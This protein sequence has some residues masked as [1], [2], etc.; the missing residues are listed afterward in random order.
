MRWRRLGLVPGADGTA[1]WAAHSALQPTPLLLSDVIRL[2]VGFRDGAGRSSVAFIDVDAE[3]PARVR[4]VADVPA[5]A[6]GRPGGFDQ[7]GVVPC[8]VVRCGT[9]LRLYYAGYERGRDV[10]FRVFGGVAESDDD[11][12]TFTRVLETPVTPATPG[13][14]LFRVIHS[15]RR[16]G[17]GWR[18]WY[19]GGDGFIAGGDSTRPV[20]DIRCM[21]S[22]DGITFPA[23]GRV[24]VE[25]GAGEYR[26]GRPFVVE[27]GPGLQMFFGA[28]TDREDYRLAYA[29]SVDGDEWVR[30]DADLG[31]DRAP[32]GFDSQAMGYPAVLDVD[33]RR[34][35]FYNGND[36]GRDGV[37][38]AVLEGP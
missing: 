13:E 35:M 20:Y 15:I 26:V 21:D 31:F 14:S 6:P 3:Q 22:A 12:E 8:A 18:A 23:S 29:E 11:G 32:A 37:G 10:R 30:R 9:V 33:G 4:R 38:V 2:F 24:V 7:D 27:G 1:P 16:H 28:S 5:L 34:L 25:L 19:G 17:D 36:F